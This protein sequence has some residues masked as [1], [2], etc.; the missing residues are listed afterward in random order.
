MQYQFAAQ[1]QTIPQGG[2]GSA[3][4]PLSRDEALYPRYFSEE[5]VPICIVSSCERFF[6]LAGKIAAHLWV[7]L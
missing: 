7:D 1:V 4:S 2:T 5:V 3:C 6:P